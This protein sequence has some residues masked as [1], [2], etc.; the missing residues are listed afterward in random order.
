M[1][2]KTATGTT[3]TDDPKLL[4]PPPTNTTAQ[5]TETKPTQGEGFE[6]N[7]GQARAKDLSS[8]AAKAEVTP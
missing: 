2:L 8:A 4:P 5:L 7:A 1:R 6:L 3:A